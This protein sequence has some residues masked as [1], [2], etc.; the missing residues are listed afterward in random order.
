MSQLSNI[1]DL[2][3]VS[4]ILLLVAPLQAS[5]QMQLPTG[6]H[7][8]VWA[9][10]PDARSLTLGSAGTVFVG[11][12]RDGRVFALRDNDGDGKADRRWTLLRGLDMPNGVAFHGGALYVAESGAIWRLAHIE[13]HL[14]QPPA[15]ELVHKLKA[16]RHHGWRYIA[17]GPDGRL[18]V[19]LGA[20]CNVCEPGDF[21]AIWRLRPDGSDFAPYALGVRNSVGL[22][23]HPRSGELW[24]TDNGRDWLGDD[25]PSDELNH[26]TAADQHFGFPY[27]H[28]GD[29]PDP[30]FGAG[31]P[32]SEF[33]PPVQKLGAHVAAL[34]L[35]FYTGEQFPKPY[36]GQVLIAQHGSWNRSTPVGYRLSLVRLAADRAVA[37]RPLVSGW[38]AA[39]GRVSGRPVDLLVLGDGSLLISDD[40][41]GRIWRLSYNAE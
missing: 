4:F 17:F 26:A 22:A 34:G 32:C 10:V 5:P 12:R 20:P 3:I 21:G 24:F 29:L 40:A 35:R 25:L 13:A 36:R 23:F 15:P 30:D 6:F 28:G 1:G 19:S 39:D 11:T 9:K 7:L 14:D 38:L 27:C 18:Y 41:G 16:Y 37:Y 8:S 31:H 2:M 33:V